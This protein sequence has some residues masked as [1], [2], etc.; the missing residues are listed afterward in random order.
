MVPIKY[1]LA[2]ISLPSLMECII[3]Y[4]LYTLNIVYTLSILYTLYII[5]IYT[6]YII[7]S[8]YYNR[9]HDI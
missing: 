2:M 9:V 3:Y 7:Y 6:L 5:I 8:V 4:I 1:A